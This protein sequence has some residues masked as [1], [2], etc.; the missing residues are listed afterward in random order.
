MTT[1]TAILESMVTCPQCGHATLEENAS[2]LV[3]ILPCVR[4]MPYWLDRD[5]QERL[6]LDL[7]HPFDAGQMR[8]FKASPKVNSVRNNGPEMLRYVPRLDQRLQTEAIP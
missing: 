4:R 5:E 1:P 2:R 6:P 3:S 7:L 8:I